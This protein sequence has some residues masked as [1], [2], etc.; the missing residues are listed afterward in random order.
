MTEADHTPDT[1]TEAV[2]AL[3]AAG[4]TSPFVQEGE[5]LVCLACGARHALDFGVVERFYRFEGPSDPGDEAIVLG[6][7]CGTCGARGTL[8][9]AFGP[10]ADP[11]AFA[12][13]ARISA[14]AAARRSGR[15]TPGAA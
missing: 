13:L 10:D 1:V 9:S 5:S 6:V 8:V 7:R 15:S 3:E 11:D 2:A 12:P 4:Y 14:E